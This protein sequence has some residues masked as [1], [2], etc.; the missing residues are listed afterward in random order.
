MVAAE[1]RGARRAE[2]QSLAH[3]MENMWLKATVLNLDFMILSIL[4]S[5]TDNKEF[6]DLF[7]FPVGRYGFHGCV[8]GYRAGQIREPR[9]ATA[10]IHW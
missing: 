9:Y 6:C 5:M 10:E 3:M 7:R 1:L 8:I 4:E 2:K